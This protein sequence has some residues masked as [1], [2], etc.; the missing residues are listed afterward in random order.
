MPGLRLS[1]RLILL[2]TAAVVSCAPASPSSLRAAAF[3]APD[4]CALGSLPSEIQ[5]RLK[6]DFEAWKIQAADNLSEHARKSW[7]GK[8]PSGCPGIAVGLFQGVKVPSYAFLLVPVEHPDSGYR[9]LV[10]SRKTGQLSYEPIM[11]EKSDERGASN[12]F[13][14]KVLV[15]ELFSEEARKKFQVQTTQ[16]VL[17]VDSAEQEYETDI[18][19]WSN[20][21]YQ[22]QP[23]DD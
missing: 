15:N 2:I 14:R 13:I 17:M 5:I 23:V 10:F 8:K 6:Q 16:A 7:D 20:G 18:Y 4:P 1:F 3:V 19:F 21:R 11:I 9:F 22:H 12:Y